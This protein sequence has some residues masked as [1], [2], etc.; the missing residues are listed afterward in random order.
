MKSTKRLLNS[1]QLSKR[2]GM[3]DRV[4]GLCVS[5][6]PKLSRNWTKG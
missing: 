6:T 3:V 2:G 5:A 4:V 1:E